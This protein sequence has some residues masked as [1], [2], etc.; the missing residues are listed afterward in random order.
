MTDAADRPRYA[1]SVAFP[2]VGREGQRRLAAGRVAIVGAGAL[3]A[4]LGEQL[5]RSGVGFTRVIDRDVLEESNLGRQALYTAEDAAR[6]LPKAV[7]L[8]AHL[9]RFNPE[10]VVEPRVEDLSAENVEDLLGDVDVV[11]DGTDNFETRY[12]VNDLAVRRGTPWVYGACVAARGLS[13]VVLPGETPC[14]RCLYPDPPPP[15]SAET[16]ET[17]GILAPTATLVASLEA[18]EVLKLLVGAKDRVRRSWLS[19][20]LWPFRCVELGADDSRPD[21]DC[22][23]CGRREFPFLEGAAGPRTIKYCGRDAVQVIPGRR[24]ALDLAALEARLRA[25]GRVERNEFLLVLDAPPHVVTVFADG[26]ALVKGV[27]DPAEARS[28]YDRFVGS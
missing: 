9:R 16:C 3:G 2:G 13:A 21:P 26:R 22:P 28:L 19:V 23:C 11:V 15:G 20:E 5:V 7:A 8:A 18:V 6:R 4:S 24:A 1:R 10:V 14:L 12:L 17:A 27:K 25:A